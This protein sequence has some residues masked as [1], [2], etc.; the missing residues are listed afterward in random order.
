M[1]NY[2]IDI[3]ACP[4]CGSSLEEQTSLHC[5]ACRQTF[6]RNETGSLDMR[7]RIE[8]T[9]EIVHRLPGTQSSVQ[10]LPSF[11]E[12]RPNQA[13]D[14]AFDDVR[15]PIHLTPAMASYITKAVGPDSWALD[16]GC[17]SGEY[18]APVE[19]A[20]HQWVGC[21]YGN[22]RAPILADAHS[23]PFRDETFAF[24]ISLAVLEHL[25]Q[26]SVA[27]REILRVLKPGARFLGSVAYLAP[28]HDSASYF[29]MTHEGVYRALLDAG[30]RVRFVAG[31]RK[32]MGLH[33]ICYSG[34]FLDMPR[35]LAYAI[36]NPILALSRVWWVYRRLRKRWRSS[37]EMEIAMNTGAFVF[38]A[39]K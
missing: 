5:A 28:F 26:P 8:L 29:N 23:L 6:E 33:A 22:P 2:P 20:G 17:G 3:F 34:L 30:F 14:V 21:D 7:P 10:P 11:G 35:G 38:V 24:V 37:K 12:L 1:I 25:H 4:Q 27:L 15:L 13:P 9:R 19:Y 32:Y 31:E 39:E 16:L 18:R 36:A